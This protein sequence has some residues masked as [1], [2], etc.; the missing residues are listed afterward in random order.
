LEFGLRPSIQNTSLLEQIIKGTAGIRWTGRAGSARAALPA[1]GIASFAFDRGAR[2][3]ELAI[4]SEVFLRNSFRYL[5]GALELRGCIEVTAI[6]AGPKVGFAFWTLTFQNNFDWRRDDSATQR[7][8]QD[9]LKIRHLHPTRL[10]LGLRPARP[11]FGF[12]FGFLAL[13]LA[14]PT[15]I[16][17]AVLAVFSIH[18]D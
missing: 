9:F 11:A 4:V 14:V 17:V 10:F 2:H 12:F 15:I 18:I 16:H 13:L 3:E 1:A 8:S 7:T 6:L 5:L